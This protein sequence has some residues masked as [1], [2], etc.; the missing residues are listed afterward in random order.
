MN[1]KFGEQSGFFHIID[2]FGNQGERIGISDGVG[3]QIAVILA[4][5]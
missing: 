3:V 4:G 5:T 1:V 2:E